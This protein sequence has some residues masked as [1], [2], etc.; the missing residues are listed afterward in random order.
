MT[1]IKRRSPP[2]KSIEELANELSDKP[3]GDTALEE[4]I[5]ART[6]IS[7]PSSLLYKLEDLAKRN[8]REKKAPRSVSALIRHY[9]EKNL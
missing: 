1:V 9:I 2:L 8:K 7:L 3:Y 6:T 5:L 4:D